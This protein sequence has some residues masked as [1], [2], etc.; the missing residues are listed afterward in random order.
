MNWTGEASAVE[1]DIAGISSHDS[2]SDVTSM[3]HIT[4]L[5]TQGARISTPP[6]TCNATASESERP[7]Q[8]MCTKEHRSVMMGRLKSRCVTIAGMRWTGAASHLLLTL[9]ATRPSCVENSGVRGGIAVVIIRI[10]MT[11]GP[12]N[13]LL[14]SLPE[15]S[16]V[17]LTSPRSS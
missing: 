14:R 13:P 16:P 17:Q 6:P 1:R 12:S 5:F 3:P 11:E 9:I 8:P 7:A 10:A 2:L 4:D 15:D